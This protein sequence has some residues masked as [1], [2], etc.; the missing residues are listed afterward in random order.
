MQQK[1]NGNHVI[2][3]YYGKKK[4]LNYHV[5]NKKLK[6]MKKS[7]VNTYNNDKGK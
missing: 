4:Y 3:L 2:Y 6:L 1:S 7:L 5:F